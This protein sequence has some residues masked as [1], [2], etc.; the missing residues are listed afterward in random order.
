MEGKDELKDKLI[1]YLD[2]LEQVV[3]DGVDFTSEQASM[4]AQEI[5]LW[6]LWCSASYLLMCIITV[7]ALIMVCKFCWKYTRSWEVEEDRFA[8]R[9]TPIIITGV[10]TIPISLCVI[11]NVG[12]L[13]Q[14][15]VAPRL[16]VIDYIRDIIR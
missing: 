11:I 13:V 8:A 4:V 2:T 15:I 9:A 14:A 12:N 7:F 10:V 5:V 3:E 16:V 1:G 6:T